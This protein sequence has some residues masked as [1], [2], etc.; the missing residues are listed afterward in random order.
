MKLTSTQ[1]TELNKLL[2]TA[3]TMVKRE[4]SASRLIGFLKTR[5]ETDFVKYLIKR[6]VMA[7]NSFKNR[8]PKHKK[9]RPFILEARKSRANKVIELGQTLSRVRVTNTGYELMKTTQF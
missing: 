2:Q 8:K 3:K 4:G 5:N 6:I 1:K 7:A 9:V